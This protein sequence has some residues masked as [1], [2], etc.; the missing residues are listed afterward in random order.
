MIKF[1]FVLLSMML[2]PFCMLA[3]QPAARYL[4]LA[5][6]GFIENNALQ[7]TAFVEQRWRLP[8]NTGFNESIGYVADLLAKA[9]YKVQKPGENAVLSYRIERRPMSGVTW[10][11]LSAHL[12][13]SGDKENLL[14]F[15]TNR[16]MLAINSASTPAKGLT[17]EVIRLKSVTD[18]ATAEV[19]GKIV[20][21]DQSP[22]TFFNAAM[23]AG[24][25]GVLGY[26]MPA[27][28]QPEKHVTSIQFSGISNPAD[29]GFAIN[30]SFAA[31]KRLQ[32]ALSHGPVKLDVTVQTKSYRAEELTLVAEIRGSE[33]PNERFVYSAHVQEPGA[34]DNA[35]GV[36]TLAEMARLA[37]ELQKSGKAQPGRTLTFLW[38]DEITSTRRFIKDDS[39][40]AKGI[41]W[42]MSL[43]MVGE[44]TRKTG[45]T[46]L[47]ERMPD[48]SAIWTR[49]D[50]K[51]SEWGAG[52]VTEK[53]LFPH[54]YNDFILSVCNDQGRYAGW[55]VSSN[56]FE[57]GSDHTPFLQNRIPGL[58]MWHFTDVF[59]HTDNDR[60]DKVSSA[61]MKNVGVCAL[62]AG[63]TL[64]S[65]DEKTALE[66]LQLVNQAATKRMQAEFRL[67]KAAIAAGKEPKTEKHIIES[68]A[69]WYNAALTSIGQLPV[70]QETTRL[71]SS[72]KVAVLSLEKETAAMLQ[73]L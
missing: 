58:L 34:N 41:Q 70:K 40:R 18:I 65:A 9:G 64:C 48:P 52:S 72:I 62:A 7:T 73:Q 60:L 22:G 67:S 42:G 61:T 53:D 1:R 31:R 51:H 46:F 33:K 57:G 12:R 55:Q 69:A 38:G 17:A 5:R 47:I 49:G 2:L 39:L 13:I 43:D 59:Y 10:E 50:D 23:K 21:I 4:D 11:P 63:L 24:A 68:W 35:T 36:A 54:Y 56:P 44:D 6:S 19:S 71:G 14:D 30:L 66:V 25:A 26:A 29:R 3:Q 32:E 27:Y 16:N 15:R 20:Y 37:A 8:G 45:G 28:T